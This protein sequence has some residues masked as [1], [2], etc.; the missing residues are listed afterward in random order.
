MTDD[1]QRKCKVCGA[2][3]RNKYLSTV[4]C[5]STC[6]K[7]LADGRSRIEQFEA[8]MDEWQK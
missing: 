1:P 5:D 6:K 7:A 8:E 4:T 2:R 3:V